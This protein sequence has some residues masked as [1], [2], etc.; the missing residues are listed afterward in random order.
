MKVTTAILLGSMAVTT[1][2][3]AD[4]QYISTVSCSPLKRTPI[5]GII[6]NPTTITFPAGDNVARV[7]LPDGGVWG[8]GSDTKGGEQPLGNNLTL[9]PTDTGS[10][11]M[12]VI[13][14]TVDGV[15]TVFPFA[16]SAVK[17]EN[18]ATTEGVTLNLICSGTAPRV[19]RAAAT[20]A[21]G[22][23]VSASVQTD[24]Q[25]ALVPRQTDPR[26]QAWAASLNP[27]DGLCHFTA[28]G[29]ASATAIQP[30]CP[31]TNGQ[32]T[33]MRFPGLQGK[34]AVYIVGS[35]G[36]ER[37][38]RQHADSDFVVVEQIAARFRLRL[39]PDVLDIINNAYNPYG[40]PTGTG[41][42]HGFQRDILT[43]SHR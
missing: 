3:W 23:T 35:D 9:W 1:H 22:Q 40:R 36:S 24:R 5:V 39:G 32:W 2:A 7:A 17:L 21:P 15:Q 28:Q 13:T 4:D 30:R 6:G 25:P 26:L 14:T 27:A 37:L 10:A 31:L 11:S 12:S 34:P 43:A 29:K 16:L 8:S 42:I 33:W 18:A 38:A 19:P 20:G 41:S